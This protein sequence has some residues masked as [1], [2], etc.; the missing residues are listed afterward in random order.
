MSLGFGVFLEYHIEDNGGGIDKSK[1]S[2]EQ[3]KTLR[4]MM[5]MSR[6]LVLNSIQK[7]GEV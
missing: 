5:G 6:G 2:E 1:K 7:T 3:S 4:E